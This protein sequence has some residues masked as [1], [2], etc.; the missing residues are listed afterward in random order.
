MCTNINIKMWGS[1]VTWQWTITSPVCVQCQILCFMSS[2]LSFPI[3]ILTP[4]TP[5]WH[6]IKNTSKLGILRQFLKLMLFVTFWW[7]WVMCCVLKWLK[8]FLLSEKG[9]LGCIYMTIQ[10]MWLP[11]GQQR[12]RGKQPSPYVWFAHFKKL[13]VNHILDLEF[14]SNLSVVCRLAGLYFFFLFSCSNV[15]RTFILL[16]GTWDLV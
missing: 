1:L 9:G 5:S 16:P 6:K 2:F 7:K 15:I 4:H 10:R 3:F 13:F 12:S 11:S 14:H 8:H